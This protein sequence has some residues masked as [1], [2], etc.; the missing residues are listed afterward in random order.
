MKVAFYLAHPAHYHYYKYTAQQLRIDGHEVT[1]I[2]KA[3]DVLLDLLN[4]DNET[5][6]IV[7]VKRPKNKWERITFV[8]QANWKIIKLLRHE[9]IDMI[10]GSQFSAGIRLL[11]RSTI[12][13]TAEDDA[14]ILGIYPKIVYPFSHAIVCSTKCDIGQWNKKAVKFE[15]NMKIGYIHPNNFMSSKEICV[16]YNIDTQ[17]SYFIM[18]FAQLNAHHDGGIKGLNTDIA[19]RLIDILS[20]HGQV[21]ITSERELEPQFEPYRL[22]INPIDMHHVM[23]FASLYIGDSQT[24]A[25]E[26]GILGV[27]Y[28]R[29]NGFVGRIGYL[30]ELET[31]YQLGV[32]IRPEKKKAEND[33]PLQTPYPVLH[34]GEEAMYDIVSQ[35]VQDLPKVK[36]EWAEKRTRLLSEK[37]DYAKFLTWFI[38][39]YPDS[40]QQTRDNQQ[41]NA[42]WAQ[43]K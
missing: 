36:A 22:A 10:I 28:V 35:L 20:P 12:I 15:S 29:F 8:M 7:A 14:A 5:Y 34:W 38:E 3:K 25:A 13:S 26:A 21:Y 19:Q 32:G 11:T 37:I 24:M 9:K 42:F 6:H 41:N 27:P 1:Y 33:I 2:I 31:K 4:G 39:N 43:F 18:R 17:K 30:D 40:Q 16:K 23:A